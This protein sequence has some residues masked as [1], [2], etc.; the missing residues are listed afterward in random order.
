MDAKSQT[1]YE[2]EV[3]NPKSLDSLI[4]KEEGYIPSIWT[5]SI[6]PKSG[7][8]KIDVYL[9]PLGKIYGFNRKVADN[10]VGASLNESV[11][12]W[13]FNINEYSLADKSNKVQRNGRIDYTYDYERNVKIGQ[14]KDKVELK[15]I[16]DKLTKL[17]PNLDIPEIFSRQ[18]D[19]KRS[20]NDTIAMASMICFYVLIFIVGLFCSFYLSK[21]K[22][23][24]WKKPLI[25]FM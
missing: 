4:Q 7:N 1:Y 24:L 16:G 25:F 10:V 8:D 18:Y 12:S 5:I 23:I 21:R 6:I 11:K 22:L 20:A 3:G 2:L 19:E 14:A 13:N 17:Q 9:T 15:I